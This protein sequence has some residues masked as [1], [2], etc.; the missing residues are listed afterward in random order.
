MHTLHK[1]LLITSSLLLVVGVGCTQTT[2]TNLNSDQTNTGNSNAV[3]DG[4]TNEV[5]VENTNVVSNTNINTPNTNVGANANENTNSD[6]GSEVDTSD[7]LIYTNDEY[8]F[9]FKYPVEWGSVEAQSGLPAG[10]VSLLFSNRENATDEYLIT[11]IVFVTK[12]DPEG[13]S[14]NLPSFDYQ[15]IDFTKSDSELSEDLKRPGATSDT[16]T[17]IKI[18]DKDAVQIVEIKSGLTGKQ[19]YTVFINVPDFSDKGTHFRVT[20]NGSLTDQL[21]T[22]NNNIEF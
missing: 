5:V 1:T 3:V 18:G 16:V 22:F 7:W 14:D 17:K 9:S 11:P 8:G 20:I 19:L 13:D 6:Q 2:T 21:S 4:N 15:A 10:E 12:E